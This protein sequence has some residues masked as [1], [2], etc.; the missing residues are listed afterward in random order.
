MI[1]EIVAIVLIFFAILISAILFIP[2]Y[3]A[4]DA[5]FSL[6]ET[7]TRFSLSWLGL[8]LWRSKPGIKKSKKPKVE[9]S[10][11]KERPGIR[12]VFRTIA[13]FR[14]SIPAFLIIARSAK[15]A[16]FV[17]NAELQCAFGSGDPAETAFIA[18]VLWSFAGALN[19]IPKVSINFRPMF[20]TQELNGSLTTELRIRAFP[21][22]IGFLRA[23]TKKPFRRFIK[24]ARA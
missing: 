4:L 19:R 14:E 3:V 17:R 21:L 24:E 10:Q 15:R 1:L 5:A 6:E 9:K 20:E 11:K 16:I 22:V 23:Y 18:G 8:T 13:S 2:F 12:K 7:R